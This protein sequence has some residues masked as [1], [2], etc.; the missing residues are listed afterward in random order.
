V[1]KIKSCEI[2]K[3]SYTNHDARGDQ[4]MRKVLAQNYS[5]LRHK[6]AVTKQAR[7]KQVVRID[8]DSI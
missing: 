1:K 8:R 3:Y 7:A 6:K 5:P 2:L 4:K